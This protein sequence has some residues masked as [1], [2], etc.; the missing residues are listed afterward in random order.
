LQKQSKIK[1]AKNFSVP[2]CV[3]VSFHPECE[4]DINRLFEYVII[5]V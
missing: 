4:A 1:K 3:S 2:G 5:A